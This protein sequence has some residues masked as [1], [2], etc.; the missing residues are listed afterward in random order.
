[1][2][3]HHL[4][5]L[6]ALALA[7]GDP[8]GTDAKAEALL[9]ASRAAYAALASY[10]DTGTLTHEMAGP[11]STAAVIRE[12]HTFRTAFRTPRNYLFEFRKAG[13]ERLVVWCD[14]GD[15]QSWWSASG[16]HETYAKGKGGNAFALASYPTRGAIVH[17]APLLFAAAGLQG[18][19]VALNEPKILGEE[20]LNGRRTVKVLATVGLAYGKTGTVTNT[21]ATTVWIDKAN[22]LVLKVVEDTPNTAPKGSLDRI[23]TTFEPRA[24]PRWEE[25]VFRFG[26]PR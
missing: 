16:V 3:R 12:T 23:T 19:L 25:G 22:H 18:P 13:G 17:I 21:R 5:P 11:G 9:E 4:L 1:M 2:T 8:P 14:G 6:F 24:N 20:D 7:G 10:A 26:V 15:F